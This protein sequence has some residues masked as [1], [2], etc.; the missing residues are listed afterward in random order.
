MKNTAPQPNERLLNDAMSTSSLDAFYDDVESQFVNRMTSSGPIP[1]APSVNGTHKRWLG[2]GGSAA[3]LILVGAAVVYYNT[4]QT[5]S[6]TVA[7]EHAQLQEAPASV[8]TR[9]T[10]PP[11]PT[12]PAP[13]TAPATAVQSVG[14]TSEAKVTAQARS[15]QT[16]SAQTHHDIDSLTTALSAAASPS[17]AARIGYQLGLRYRIAGD[18]AKAIDM[19]VT[20]STTAQKVGA[21]V[22]AA[23]GYQQAAK[24][25]LQL[26]D[27]S[28][29]Q[30]FLGQAL[31][32]LPAS[33]TT[34]RDRWQQEL[35]SLQR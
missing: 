29:A 31:N 16:M 2:L 18:H 15:S 9:T 17:D 25:A 1:P 28:R 11:A 3:V 26:G 6:P 5:T 27:R 8:S 12:A 21:N 7:T 13:R 32:V 24:A 35:D 33:E 34:L 22:L 4:T 10:P 20:S 19:L 23:R 14:S 30:S